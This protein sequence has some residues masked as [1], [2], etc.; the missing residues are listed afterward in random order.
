MLLKLHFCYGSG[1]SKKHFSSK[2]LL[3]EVNPLHLQYFH[4]SNWTDPFVADRQLPTL[5]SN[6][7]KLLMRER[8]EFFQLHQKS[9][10]QKAHK[11]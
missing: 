7:A 1:Y 8:V 4:R 9:L 10:N 11:S 6:A 5:F 3:D 2:R